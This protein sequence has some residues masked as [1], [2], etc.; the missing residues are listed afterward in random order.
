MFTPMGKHGQDT[1]HK[2]KQDHLAEFKNFPGLSDRVGEARK[3][4]K[5]RDELTYAEQWEKRIEAA[6]KRR[7]K[8]AAEGHELH[9]TRS[10]KMSRP[11]P[12]AKDPASENGE[13]DETAD[14]EAKE[15]ET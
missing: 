1:E 15:G 14:K 2:G 6:L 11:P 10:I 5:K 13:E 4:K 7:E 12:K 3:H 8:L 9:P